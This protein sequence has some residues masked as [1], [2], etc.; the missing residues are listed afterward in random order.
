MVS[1]ISFI[2]VIIG[3]VNWFCIGILQFDF[4]AGLFGSQAS[5]FSR[6]IYTAVGIASLVILYNLI[7]NKG[8]IVFNFKHKEKMKAN[9]HEKNGQKSTKP[10]RENNN[11]MEKPDMSEKPGI[12]SN[13]DNKQKNDKTN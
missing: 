8:K 10:E 12:T 7:D 9:S 6:T 4:V 1:L 3:A 5:I 13:T 11:T 2:L